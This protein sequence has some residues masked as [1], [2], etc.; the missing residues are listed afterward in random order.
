RA[1]AV[2]TR[3]GLSLEGPARPIAAAIAAV[4]LLVSL[5]LGLAVWRYGASKNSANAALR[6]SKTQVLAQKLR[7]AITDE[8]GIAD[9]YASDKNP[10]DLRDLA[11]VRSDFRAAL[12]GLRRN[13]ALDA[14][15]RGE[16][17]AIAAGQ[18]ELE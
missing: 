15:E 1:S 17:A 9:G 3:A 16:V 13:S 7:T 8:G 12:A 10:V 11:G 5:A 2:G 4:I 14:R 6:E 18:A